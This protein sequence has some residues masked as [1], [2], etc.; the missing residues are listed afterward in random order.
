MNRRGVGPNQLGSPLKLTDPPKKERQYPNPNISKADIASA[1]KTALASNKN[2][3]DKRIKNKAT[4]GIKVD[5]TIESLLIGGPVVKAAAK[6]VA[7]A[8]RLGGKIAS[9]SR[10]VRNVGRAAEAGDAGHVVGLY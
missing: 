4:G 9:S 10:A 7:A 1:N 2:A 5:N 8:G 3:L 6:G